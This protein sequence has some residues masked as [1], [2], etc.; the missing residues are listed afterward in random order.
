MVSKRVQILSIPI[1]VVTRAEVLQRIAAFVSSGAPHQIATVNPEFVMEAQRN[2]S[3]INALRTTSL[4]IADGIGIRWATSLRGTPVPETIPGADLLDVICDQAAEYGWPVYLVGGKPGVAAD[5]ATVLRTRFPRLVIV[6]AEEGI[7]PNATPQD[8]A[9]LVR[10]IRAAKPSILFVAFGAPKQDL[11]I[12]DNH[13]ALGVPV[14]MGV[15]G[16][17]DFLTGRAHRAP[18]MLRRLG[19]EWLWRLGTQP[20]R[21]RRIMTAVIAFP[22]AVLRAPSD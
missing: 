8:T 5:A 18:Q 4:N 14:M 12:A 13:E 3:F 1:D 16:S 2:R 20:W 6:G 9:A 17:L 21:L 11:F 19:L 7:G 10:R 15:G 22:L